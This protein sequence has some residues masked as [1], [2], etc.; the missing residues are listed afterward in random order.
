MDDRTWHDLNMDDVFRL[1]DRAESL[2]GQ[3]ALYARLRASPRGD[4]PDAFEALTARLETDASFRARTQEALH[5]MRQVDGRDLL[6]LA[7][8][9]S[10]EVAGWH[11][12]FPILGAV[13]IGSIALAVWRPVILF[14]VVIGAI[15]GLILRATAAPHLRVVASAFRQIGP[16]LGAAGSLREA[17]DART[18]PITGPLERDLPHLGRLKRVAAWGGRDVGPAA[19]G[20]LSALAIEYLN[21]AFSL[22]GN[23]VFFGTRQL[24]AHAAELTR[25]L[26]A[27]GE[28]DAA[29]AVASFRAGTKGWIRPVFRPAGAS[30]HL[31]GLRHPLIQ[32]AVPNAIDLAPPHGL[33]ITGS[34][35]SG[36][37]TFL[38]T[39]GVTAV[40]A[41]TINTCVADGYE[42]P[43]FVV[44]SYIGRADDPATGKSYYLVEVESVLE[45]VRAA[46]SAEPHLILFDE[47]FRGTNTVERI[48]AG[49]AVLV[50]LLTPGASE[51]PRPHVVIAATHDQELVD[52]LRAQYA[53]YHFTD[54]VDDAG[55]SFDYQLREGPARTRNAIALLRLRGA[56]PDLVERAT[57]RANE[58]DRRES[59]ER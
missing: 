14:F 55:L 22:D 13:M 7:E 27:V 47:L 25:V 52:L 4:H 28:I 18:A 44:R 48:A 11:V 12:V 30:A 40:L 1:L 10:F 49:E 9:G 17:A 32:E 57:A 35:M 41:Q 58:L 51:E 5:R 6:W 33:I 21:V 31:T 56:P 2:V 19:S 59:R 8:P 20:N 38:R 3:Q 50:S 37:T 15:A 26:H 45:L 46:E 16:L 53:A 36:K 39:L 24:R 29:L 43:V 54:K 34:N 42:A 23:A